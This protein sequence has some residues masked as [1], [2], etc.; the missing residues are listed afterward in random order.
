M[1]GDDTQQAVRQ[2]ES[3]GGLRQWFDELLDDLPYVL[4]RAAASALFLLVLFGVWVVGW[5]SVGD[6]AL[7]CGVTNRS[8]TTV[9]VPAEPLPLEDFERLLKDDNAC[10]NLAVELTV[11]GAAPADTVIDPLGQAV[12]FVRG[13]PIPV[14]VEAAP[15]DFW[16]EC[17]D[18]TGARAGNF[19]DFSLGG[20]PACDATIDTRC[21][22]N[23][24][25][26]RCPERGNQGARCLA[27]DGHVTEACSGNPETC[28][29][30]DGRF[31]RC[32][33]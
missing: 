6:S 31:V 24:G 16:L 25:L 23:G 10:A 28:V 18:F 3:V 11:T 5:R 20:R 26:E 15:R 27:S 22:G 17:G 7:F 30:Q 13:E 2:S 33:E 12:T 4:G 29:D 21:F 9:E 32:A 19:P 14:R 8:G 1:P